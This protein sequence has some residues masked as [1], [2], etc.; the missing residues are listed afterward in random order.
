MIMLTMGS[1]SSKEFRVGSKV[2]KVIG[3]QIMGAFFA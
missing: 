2:L 3:R 1:V